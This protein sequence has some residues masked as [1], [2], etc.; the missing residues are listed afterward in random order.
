MIVSLVLLWVPNVTI[1]G[2]ALLSIGSTLMFWDRHPFPPAHRRAVR[3]AYLLFWV[4]AGAY[5]VIFAVFV[6]TAYGAWLSSRRLDDL[7]P[8]IELFVWLSTVPTELL[9]AAVALQIRHLLPPTVRRQVPWAALTLGGLVGLATLLAY[10]DVAAG[11]GSEF[12]R[13]SSVLGILNRISVARLVEGPGFAWLAYLYYRAHG[14]IVPKA[15]PA[16]EG[17]PSIPGP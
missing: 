4:S 1:L 3:V 15:A 17:A 11:L 16:G 12:V 13:M 7:R 14:A 9:V 8:A 5:A 2:A 10:W 6:S